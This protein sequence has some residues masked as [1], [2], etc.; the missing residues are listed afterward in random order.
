[1]ASFRF[2]LKSKFRRR[3]RKQLLHFVDALLLHLEAG[4]DL[5]YA[6]SAALEVTESSANPEF[7]NS[8]RPT[9]EQGMADLLVRIAKSYPNPDHGLWFWVIRELY[10]QGAGVAEPVRAM[11][12]ALRR[13]AARDLDEHCRAL[14]G[15]LNLLLLLFFLPPTLLLL[16]VPLLQSMIRAFS[17]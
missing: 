7:L 6:W 5:A 17:D 16:F 14:P 1:M 10:S 9:A 3:D 12:A 2:C 8:L 11:A 15:R 13:E 4:Y